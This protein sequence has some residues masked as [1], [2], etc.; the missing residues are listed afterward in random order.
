MAQPMYHRIADELRG[1]IESGELAPG[2]Q[3]PTELELREAYEASRNTVR[4]AIRRLIGLGLVETKPGQGTFVTRKIDPFVTT[5]TGNT[6]TGR[7]SSESITY[8]SDVAADHRRPKVSAPR[9][10]IQLAP[11]PIAL[12]LRIT[13]GT[14]VISRHQERFINDTPWSL[15]TSFYPIE[16]ITSGRAPK[17]LMAEDIPEGVVSY[18]ELTMGI[19]E[20]GYR[21]WITGRP[22]DQNEQV[23]FRIPHDSTV[24]EI[25]RTGFDESGVPFRLTVTVYPADRNQFIVD[26]GN[27]PPPRYRVEAVRKPGP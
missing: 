1:R 14:Q 23:F 18:L 27:V 11:D 13:P 7:V 16:F 2:A 17:M 4:D 12:R 10:E 15:Q 3:L 22:P 26:V 21:D 5:L 24:F 20:A 8:L 6:E 25:F 9:V 19:K